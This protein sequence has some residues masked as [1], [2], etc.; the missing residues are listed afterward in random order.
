VLAT[1][2]IW[3]AST[4]TVGADDDVTQPKG[5]PNTFRRGRV[6]RSRNGPGLVFTLYNVRA[7]ATGLTT[8]TSR[9]TTSPTIVSSSPPASRR[10]ATGAGGHCMPSSRSARVT[11]QAG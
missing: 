9:A 11:W 3:W 6:G 10:F 7:R 2:M 5:T 8:S 1:N 4:S